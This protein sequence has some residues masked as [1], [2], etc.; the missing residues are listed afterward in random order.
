MNIY[1]FGRV[2]IACYHDWLWGWELALVECN[3]TGWRVLLGHNI[4][5]WGIRLGL[6]G[7]HVRI[8]NWR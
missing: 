6:L 7:F 4:K 1:K 2:E 5:V 8:S 3:V